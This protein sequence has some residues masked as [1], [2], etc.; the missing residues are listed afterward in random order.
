MGQTLWASRSH[1]RL[2]HLHGSLRCGNAHTVC[3]HSNVSN[4]P[5]L[6]RWLFCQRHIQSRLYGRVPMRHTLPGLNVNFQPINNSKFLSAST[7]IQY[8]KFMGQ[9]ETQQSHLGRGGANKEREIS[10][11]Q[12]RCRNTACFVPKSKEHSILGFHLRTQK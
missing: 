4:Y 6:P 1:G 12:L 11:I 5:H 8:K 2:S 9:Y 7:V 3:M 10:M